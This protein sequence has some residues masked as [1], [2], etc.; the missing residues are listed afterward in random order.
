RGC[1]A[2]LDEG[3]SF[4]EDQVAKAWANRDLA[5]GILGQLPQVRF[6][7]PPG[8]FYLF[9]RLE[10]MTDSLRTA[11]RIIDEAGVGF[12][13][14]GTFGASGAGV[15]RMCFLSASGK[16]A[17]APERFCSRLKKSQPSYVAD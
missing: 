8:A 5:I 17:Q 7:P 11:I 4:V 10:G 3:E 9:F 1:V 14:G 2:A 15:L 12:A 13:P 16:L 6:E